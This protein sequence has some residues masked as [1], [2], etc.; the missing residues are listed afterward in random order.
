MSSAE[1]F[2]LNIQCVLVVKKRL[3]VVALRFVNASHVVIST[4]HAHMTSAE[5]FYLD[6]QRLLVQI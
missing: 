6:I 2:Y 1:G 4:R 3:F 5:G